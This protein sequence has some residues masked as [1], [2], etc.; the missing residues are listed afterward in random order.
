M[1]EIVGLAARVIGFAA[2]A[3]CAGPVHAE[4]VTIKVWMHEHPP[5][6]PI[7]RQI[8]AEFEKAHPDVKV[9][10]QVIAVAEYPTKLLTAFASGSGPDV[11]NQTVSLVAQYYASRILA[12]IDYAALGYPDEKA[13]TDQYT[14]GFA[15]IRFGGKLYGVPTEVSNYACYLNNDMWKEAGLDPAKDFPTTWEAMPALAE[16]LTKR[17]ANGVPI[18]RGFDFNWPTPGVYWLTMNTMMHQLG[19]SLIDEDAYKAT[20]EGPAALEATQF[21]VDWVNKYKL[22]GPQYTDTRTDFLGKKL[23]TECSFGIWGIPQMH[24]AKVNFTVKPVPRFADGKSDEG[25]DAY[26]YYMMVNARSSPAVQKASWE[27]V[28]MFTDHAVDLFKGAGLFV[29]RKDVA[30]LANDP[31]SLVFLNELKKAKFSPRVVGYNQVLDVLMRGR[32]RMVQGGEPV[33]NVIPT[34]NNDMNGVLRREKTRAEAM[35]K[36]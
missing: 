35:L 25:F 27:F 32:D 24:D 18:R 20:Y 4:Q 29:P 23:A 2:F 19:A 9:D 13:L 26:A 31:D 30:P 1:R 33:A 5:R 28:R 10:Y 7:D 14:S 16:K 6:I 22:G 34:V 36:Q 15:G 21:L 17:D 3:A 11:F 8:V 12:P